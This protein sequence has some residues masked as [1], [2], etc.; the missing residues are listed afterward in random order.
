MPG[1]RDIVVV[2]MACDSCSHQWRIEHASPMGRPTHA[3]I[4]SSPQPPQ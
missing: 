4:S 3:N 1:R 2:D